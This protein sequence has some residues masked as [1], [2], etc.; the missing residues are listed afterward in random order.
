MFDTQKLCRRKYIATDVKRVEVSVQRKDVRF[1][2]LLQTGG[3]PPWYYL[4][5]LGHHSQKQSFLR[6]CTLTIG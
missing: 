6:W 4:A 5:F 2:R 3:S 1:A